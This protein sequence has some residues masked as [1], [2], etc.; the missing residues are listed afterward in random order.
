MNSTKCRMTVSR[1]GEKRVINCH[2]GERDCM[3]RIIR[4]KRANA[5]DPRI[6]LPRPTLEAMRQLAAGRYC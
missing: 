2:P 4:G 1:R 5:A 6:A 3:A